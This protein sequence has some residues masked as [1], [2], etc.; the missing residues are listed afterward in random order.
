MRQIVLDSSL[1]VALLVPNDT[2]HSQAVVL[3]DA[4]KAAGYIS[5]TFDCVVAEAV[6]VA[7][8][9]LYEKGL[10]HEIQP[11]LDRFNAQVSPE[12]ITWIFPD[13]PRLYPEVLELMRSS[14]GELNFNDALIALVCRERVIPAIA[15]FDADFD[16]V[17]WLKR[18]AGPQDV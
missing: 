10:R 16:Q 14:S 18:V 8:R 9:R 13:A 4:I 15:S 12:A 7:V 2:W 5:I 1:L 6:S 17:P 3:W 11:L